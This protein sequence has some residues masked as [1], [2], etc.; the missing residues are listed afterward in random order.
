MKNQKFYSRNLSL[1]QHANRSKSLSQNKGLK[2]ECS[3]LKTT[4]KNTTPALSSDQNQ[5]KN[6]KTN[7]QAP[8]QQKDGVLVGVCVQ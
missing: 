4:F 3:P 6:T 5:S 2:G 1:N 8:Q 7:S